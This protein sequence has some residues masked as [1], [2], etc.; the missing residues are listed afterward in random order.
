MAKSE[1]ERVRRRLS[2]S[3][4]ASIFHPAVV[5]NRQQQRGGDSDAVADRDPALI[6]GSEHPA[7]R[8]SQGA[9]A[10]AGNQFPTERVDCSSSPTAN[11]KV[12]FSAGV[13]VVWRRQPR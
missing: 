13:A 10:G 8:L 3:G 2:N 4:W 9:R 5:S 1:C 7:D 11:T 6:A 12:G